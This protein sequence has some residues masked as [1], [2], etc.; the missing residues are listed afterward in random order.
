MQFIPKI[1]TK[2]ARGKIMKLE[3]LI[4][5]AK[6]YEKSQKIMAKKLDIQESRFSDW[7][8]GRTKPSP[9]EIYR[10]A[11]MARVQPEKAFYEVMT[12]IDKENKKYWC[13][14]LESNQRPSASEVAGMQ[15]LFTF[16]YK[17]ISQLKTKSLHIAHNQGERI[18]LSNQYHHAPANL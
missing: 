7:K 18:S 4:A 2:Q 1:G 17:V 9:F 6:Y 15:I 11:E 14:R 3:M 8:K 16:I 13:A 10:M 5:R 12:E